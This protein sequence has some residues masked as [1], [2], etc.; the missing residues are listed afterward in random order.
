M[1]PTVPEPQA[2]SA[3]LQVL[4]CED[5]RHMR[6]Y[7]VAGLEGLGIQVAGV[8]NGRALDAALEARDPQIV[9]LDVG[10]PGEDGF[11]IARRLRRE[12]P[13]LGIIM[14]TARHDLEDRIR[15]LDGGA[16]L[17]YAKPV[18]LR[19]LASAINSL[20]RRLGG[21][22][23]WRL[24]PHA[25]RLQSPAG[26]AVDLT[27]LELRF[28]TPLLERPGEVVEREHLFLALDQHP[29][30]Y[31]SRRMETMVS[32]LRSKVRRLCPGEQLPVKARNGRGYAFL[33][34]Y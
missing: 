9:L 27:D 4:V 29:D 6:D 12:R 18:D 13:R 22:G 34:D 26:A 23:A 1:P 17:Y 20:R 24:E 10:L 8:E 25:S 30:I 21:T 28:L 5:S 31:A 3:G 16:D 32:R 7:L 33:V 11:S 15:G 19:E 14:L 2:P